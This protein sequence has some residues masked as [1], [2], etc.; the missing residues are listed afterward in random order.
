MAMVTLDEVQR[1]YPG[2]WRPVADDRYAET[3]GKLAFVES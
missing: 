1:R 2:V 3:V